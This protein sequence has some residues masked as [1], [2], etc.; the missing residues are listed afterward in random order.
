MTYE[1]SDY[2]G[3]GEYKV[4]CTGDCVVGDEVRFDRATFSG[5]Y[6]KPKFSGFERVTGKIIRDSYGAEKQQHTFTIQL[7]DGTTTRIKGRNLYANG[8]YRKQWADEDDRKS[9]L[10]E[11]HARGAR[12]R[13]ARAQRIEERS[14]YGY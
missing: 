13:N 1:I 7:A 10:T 11:K 12:A 5:S 8:V 6:R 2:T 4:N 3:D 9:V 14:V